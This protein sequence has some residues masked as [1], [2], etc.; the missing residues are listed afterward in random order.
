[1]KF[2]VCSH[3]ADVEK[4]QIMFARLNEPGLGSTKQKSSQDG[5][6][7]LSRWAAF[8]GPSLE[9]GLLLSGWA[10]DLAHYNMHVLLT[11]FL[12]SPDPQVL[13]RD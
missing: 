2:I 10:P 11:C 9:F 7:K 4:C 6:G 13:L 8:F 3:L 5:P 12:L 1:M